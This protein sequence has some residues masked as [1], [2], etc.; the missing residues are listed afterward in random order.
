[1]SC[2]SPGFY[3]AGINRR[4][5]RVSRPADAD[6]LGLASPATLHA[7]I[8]RK[9]DRDLP[10]H[11]EHRDEFHQLLSAPHGSVEVTGVSKGGF[12]HRRFTFF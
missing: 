1:M 3:D 9:A 7:R 4:G 10:D 12:T 11:A 5:R 6:D 8:K 2:V